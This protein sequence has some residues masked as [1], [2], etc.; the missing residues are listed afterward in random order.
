MTLHHTAHHTVHHDVR[1][2]LAEKV[3]AAALNDRYISGD[4]EKQLVNDAVEH[5]LSADFAQ[6]VIASIAV[7][8]GF[9]VESYLDHV[10]GVVLHHL[11]KK[12]KGKIDKTEFDES[13]EM[14]KDL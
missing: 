13:I 9:V 5:G 7:E 4:V 10:L 3:K 11:G 14:A 6:N 2:K 12:N 8:K 1:H